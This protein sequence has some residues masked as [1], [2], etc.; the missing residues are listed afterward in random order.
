MRNMHL[1][2]SRIDVVVPRQPLLMRPARDVLY[3][4]TSGLEPSQDMLRVPF[5]AGSGLFGQ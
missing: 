3:G 1:Q 5:S 2:A 4:P